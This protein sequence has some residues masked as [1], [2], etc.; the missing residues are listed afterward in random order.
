MD[1]T[2]EALTRAYQEVVEKKKLDPVDNKE[3]EKDFDDR[4]DQD[5]D[6]DGDVDKSDKYLHKRRK[7]VKKAIKKSNEDEPDGENGETAVMN[8]KGEQK[9]G[10]K[11]S[12]TIRNKLLSVLEK[13]DDH[14]KGASPAEPMDNNLKGEGAKKMKSDLEKGSEVNDTVSKGH[15]DAS[16][17]GRVT[18]KSKANPTDKDVKGDMNVINKPVDITQKGG[19]K[20]STEE[21]NEELLSTLATAWLA[22][23]LLPLGVAA[24]LIAF[25][26]VG[27]AIIAALE[28][29]AKLAAKIKRA[30]ENMDAAKVAKARERLEK[31]QEMAKGPKGSMLKSIANRLLSV[32]K[33]KAASG[34]KGGNPQPTGE[35]LTVEWVESVI[36]S[37]DDNLHEWVD[38]D[39]YTLGGKN[40]LKGIV[41]AYQ[42]MY[43]LDEA[44]ELDELKGAS[45]PEARKAVFMRRL[46]RVTKAVDDH[47]RALDKNRMYPSPDAR[48]KQVE[49]ER[50]AKLYKRAM[51]GAKSGGVDVDKAHDKSPSDKFDDYKDRGGKL[52]YNQYKA[53]Y[54]K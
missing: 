6:N 26:G 10:V 2:I 13:R 5:I 44:E 18:K 48:K 50:Q 49:K 12:M 47:E 25:A 1:K 41:D 20:E 51:K 36:R 29:G 14:Y 34:D 17:A 42:S 53:R 30:K 15:D 35:G 46:D 33:R 23:K 24:T 3:L 28:G 27:Y 7:T 16:K 39:S 54:L 31:A 52:S 8:P 37:V 22:S 4:D 11:E 9:E 45:D 19:V 38:K 40:E 21:L 32:F 43:E